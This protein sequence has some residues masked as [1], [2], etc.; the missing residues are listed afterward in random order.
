MIKG[1]KS[2]LHTFFLSRKLLTRKRL[3][4]F[5]CAGGLVTY[6]VFTFAVFREIRE[7][8]VAVTRDF[9]ELVQSLVSDRNDAEIVLRN[10][11]SRSEYPVIVTDTA[12]RPMMWGK[13]EYGS[14]LNRKTVP[15]SHLSDH[16]QKILLKK[17]VSFRKIYPPLPL[18]WGEGGGGYLLCGNNPLISSLV[19]LPF[20]EAVLIGVL[21]VLAYFT[22]HTIRITERSNLW[23]GMAKETAHQLGTPISSLMGWVE[24]IRTVKDADPPL[25]P[26]V[27]L[28]QSQ[29]ICDDMDNDLHR[30]RKVTARFSQIG[31]IPT[32]TSCDINDNLREVAEYFRMRLP[33]L[34]KRIEINFDLG[35]IPP[36]SA[37]RD[38]IE[39]VFE[40][41][42]KNSIDAIEKENGKI[43]IRTECL[44]RER[45]VRISLRDNG[46]GISWEAHK[47][48]FSPGYSTKKR[49]WGL[50]LTLAKRIVEDYHKGRIFVCW[51][52]KN[53]GT[54]FCVDLPVWQEP[55][56]GEG[57]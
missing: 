34:R 43:E 22:F 5:F 20:M 14:F 32:L 37:N 15:G 23:V 11:I 33:L 49:G 56:S 10:I 41:L 3:L 6:N 19:F 28:E 25:E 12:F 8:S 4:L 45:M 2:A 48:V 27:F 39:W 26:Q 40:N 55:E 24:Y 31:S 46:K 52:S 29:R 13:I 42:L 17:S 51:S 9:A 47:K 57:V 54:E 44:E 30:L 35:E 1:I 21:L 16:Q 50:G 36:V 53:K 7:D 18:R 38:L